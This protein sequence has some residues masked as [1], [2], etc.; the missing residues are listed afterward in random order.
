MLFSSLTFL[1]YFLPVVLI[2]YSLI[3]PGWRPAFLLAASLVFYGWLNPE[4]LILILAETLLGFYAGLWISKPNARK[5]R[6][7]LIGSAALLVI[8]FCFFKYTDFVIGSINSAFHS[9]LKLLNIVLPLGISFYTFQILS[10][11]MDLEKGRIAVQP[12]LIRFACYVTMFPQLVAGPI[13][14]YEQIEK[15]LA[16]PQTDFSRYSR[17]LGRFVCG[18]AKKVLIANQ[19]FAFCQAYRLCPSPSVLYAWADALGL[20]L[21]TYF[22]FSGYSD[23]AIGLGE[24]LG[25]SFPENFR[26]P[27]CAGSIK[28]FWRRWHMSLTSW[29]RDYVY[30]PLGGSWGTVPHQLGVLLCVWFLTGIW[31]GAGWTFIL[32]GLYFFSLLAIERFCPF[33]SKIPKGLGRILTFL[34]VLFGFLLFSDETIPLFIADLKTLFGFGQIPWTNAETLWNL[35]NALVLFGTALF[36]ATPWP[37]QWFEKLK[38][39]G[40]FDWLSIAVSGVVLIV[41]ISYLVWGSFNPFLYFRF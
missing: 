39:L 17:G 6:K 14:R 31:H 12:S 37:H 16:A 24:A 28:E 18:L 34:L 33:V 7:I 41:C 22:D 38:A 8:I 23:M 19:L 20:L 40:W 13:V 11:L 9:S 35:K 32:W 5:G 21:Y 29:F 3:K 4:Y 2:L 1:L 26:Y 10:Y 25:F 36:G 30:I 15:D 27:L